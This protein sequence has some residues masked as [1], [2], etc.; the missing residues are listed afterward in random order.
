[1]LRITAILV[2]FG[3][4]TLAGVRAANRL[5]RRVSQLS[6]LAAGA[7][8]LITAARVSRAPLAD[9]IKNERD[10]PCAAVFG[11]FMAGIREGREPQEAATRALTSVEGLTASDRTAAGDLLCSLAAGDL[12][13]TEQRYAQAAAR[14]AGGLQE[15]ECDRKDKAKLYR[16]IGVLG[17]AVLAVLL[18]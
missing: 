4:C 7:A 12:V 3:V 17:G 9:L 11:A 15:A 5:G 8:R 13:T 10:L 6:G 2:C 18:W 14:L 16:I 1:M